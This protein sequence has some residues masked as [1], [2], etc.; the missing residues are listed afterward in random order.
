MYLSL[1]LYSMLQMYRKSSFKRTREGSALG[2]K[3]ESDSQ[4]QGIPGQLNLKEIQ[5]KSNGFYSVLKRKS[6]VA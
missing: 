2:V 3:R 4:E 1:V 5:N 6:L